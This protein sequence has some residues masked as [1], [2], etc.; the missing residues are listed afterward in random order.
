VA[1]NGY[2]EVMTAEQTAT[3]RAPQQAHR[4]RRTLV[5]ADLA[6]LH[7]P[8]SGPV[9]LPLRLFWYPDRMFDLD[10]PGML[11]WMYQTVLRE[12]TQP[13]DLTAF[14]D[15]DTLAARWPELFLPRG[16]RAA[17][18]DQHPTLR[19]ASAATAA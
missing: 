11:D 7:G 5:A 17:W 13:A 9:E 8:T 2:P 15:G 6:E 10:A 3:L 12:A 19:A 1:G 14:L 4:G 16:V 18:E